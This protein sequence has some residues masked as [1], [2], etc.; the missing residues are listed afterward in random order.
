MGHRRLL[1]V[2]AVSDASLCAGACVVVLVLAAV[3]C[4]KAAPNPPRE[5]VAPPAPSD[6][7][8]GGT[9]GN[10]MYATAQM[11]GSL[12]SYPMRVGGTFKGQVSAPS[13]QTTPEALPAPT[14]RKL[15]RHGTLGL[16]VR[17][18][19][20]ALSAVKQQAQASGGY[21]TE[22]S[23]RQDEYGVKTA[24]ITWRVPAEKLDGAIEKLSGLGRVEQVSVTAEDVTEQYFDLEI[25]LNNQ[26]QLEVRLLDLLKRSSNNLSDLLNVER[27]VARVRGEIEHLEG[28]KRFWDNQVA[29]STLTVNLHEPRPV[30]ASTEGG[31]WRTLT[32]SFRDAGENFVLTTAG[33]IGTIG[34]LIP[35]VIVLVLVIWAI[36]ALWRWRRKRHA[37]PAGV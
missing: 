31:V 35:V 10:Q 15:I 36:R 8:G 2:W 19:E 27:E 6:A 32:A 5:A 16:E 17:S 25:R 1:K 3:G 37:A 18:V 21:T 11:A 4:S 29:L 7:G 26:R 12:K 33:I 24:S 22:E 30:I 23:Q 13:Q 9:A 14:G 20:S 34:G 28:R